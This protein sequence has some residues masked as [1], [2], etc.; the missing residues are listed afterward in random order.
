MISWLE[1]LFNATGLKGKSY[2]LPFL[3]SLILEVSLP[4][5]LGLAVVVVNIFLIEPGSKGRTVGI[6]GEL[7][8]AGATVVVVVKAMFPCIPFCRSSDLSNIGSIMTLVESSDLEAIVSLTL[9]L[10]ELDHQLGHPKGLN[11]D[12]ELGIHPA[13]TGCWGL[14]NIAKKATSMNLE[15][16]FAAKSFRAIIFGCDLVQKI[17]GL[18]SKFH[19]LHKTQN[20]TRM[21]ATFKQV[22]LPPR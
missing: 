8:L 14:I 2:I 21:G 20:G 18:A 12:Q 17:C 7:S 4:I 13:P 11:A 19:T 16:I 3:L 1:L 15:H 5:V 10:F 6:E 22:L 9:V